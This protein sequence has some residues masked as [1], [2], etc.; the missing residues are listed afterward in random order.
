MKLSERMK[1]V[2][3]YDVI[4]DRFENYEVTE[5]QIDEVTQLEAE[6]E[7][8]Q[9]IVR[10]MRLNPGEYASVVLEWLDALF[11]GGTDD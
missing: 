8:Y 7:R 2:P 11:M 10:L 6:N 5:E 4:F 3:I 9:E 1:S